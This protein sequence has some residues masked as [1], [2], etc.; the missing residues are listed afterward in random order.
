LCDL[1]K[2]EYDPEETVVI[3]IKKKGKSKGRSYDLSPE[4]ASKLEQQL[5]AGAEAQLTENW[6]FLRDAVTTSLEKTKGQTLE[7]LEDEESQFIAE[8]R[9]SLREEGVS[10]EE[11]RQPNAPA[12]KCPTRH[13]NKGRIQTTIRDGKRFAYRKCNDCNADIPEQTAEQR[14][15]YMS[16]KAPQGVNIR[17]L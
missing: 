15:N 17:D 2:L 11:R 14:K 7:D 13:M 3:T 6:S 12:S 10:E 1:T 4:A 9:A 5:V 8:K 16:G